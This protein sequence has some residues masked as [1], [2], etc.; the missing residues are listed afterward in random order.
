MSDETQ[1]MLVPV[2][3]KPS[4]RLKVWDELKEH[5]NTKL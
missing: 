1:V 3:Y 2:V 5:Y 4:Q